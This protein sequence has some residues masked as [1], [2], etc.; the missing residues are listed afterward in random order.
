MELVYQGAQFSDAGEYTCTASNAHDRVSQKITVRVIERP[1]PIVKVNP[2]SHSVKEDLGETVSF[3]C[4][5]QN[6]DSTEDIYW[7]HNG[8]RIESDAVTVC[9]GKA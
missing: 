4:S 2:P 8:K 3:Y 5:V 7:S 6:V 1:P 9:Y